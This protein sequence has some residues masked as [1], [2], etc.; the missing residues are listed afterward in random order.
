MVAKQEPVVA[1]KEEKPVVKRQP[2]VIVVPAKRPDPPIIIVGKQPEKKPTAPTVLPEPVVVVK[3][4]STLKPP[5]AKPSPESVQYQRQPYLRDKSKLSRM[6]TIE[7]SLYDDPN[8][9]PPVLET[10]YIQPPIPDMASI[11][12]LH[13]QSSWSRFTNK[14]CCSND[15]GRNTVHVQGKRYHTTRHSAPVPQYGRGRDRARYHF[16]RDGVLHVVVGKRGT[17]VVRPV[18]SHAARRQ[19]HQLSRPAQRQSP[20]RVRERPVTVESAELATRRFVENLRSSMPHPNPSPHR[21][22]DQHSSHQQYGE[23]R[24]RSRTARP[25]RPVQ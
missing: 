23:E 6:Q 21:V 10:P 19:P 4:S 12:A 1:A 5:T 8:L 22:H 14:I 16:L 2:S 17:A 3:P 15:R 18:L 13:E 20:I 11:V 9:G 7:S 24:G 25:L